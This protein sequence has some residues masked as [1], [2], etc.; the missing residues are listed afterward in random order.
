MHSN[1][2][3]PR[4]PRRAGQPGDRQPRPSRPAGEQ[5]SRPAGSGSRRPESRRRQPPRRSGGRY[6]RRA[7]RRPRWQLPALIGGAALL[8]ALVIFLIAR[9]GG[10]EDRPDKPGIF[11]KPDATQETVVPEK[12]VSTVTLGSMGDLVM[13]SQLLK[14]ARQED[15]SY[16]FDYIFRYLGDYVAGL[17]YAAV[18]LETS[19]GGPDC[20]TP[21]QGNPRF[22]T[23]DAILDSLKKAG[24]DMMLTANNHMGDTQSEGVIR[25][26]EQIRSRDL[27]ALGTNLPGEDTRYSMVELDGI[28]LGLVNYTFAHNVSDDGR[29]SLNAHDFLSQK[30]LVNFFFDQRLDSF[31]G[32]L[33]GILQQMEADGANFKIVYLHWGTEYE[34]GTTAV[35]K[36]IAQKLC[37]LGVDVIIGGHPHVAEP[38]ELLSSQ[39]DPDHKTVCLYS[40]GNFVSN[41][42]RE[43]MRLNT[44]HTEDGLMFN[45]TFEKYS[46]G[47]PYLLDVDVLPT[48]VKMGGDQ[49]NPLD[50]AVLPLDKETQSQWQQLY[51]LTDAQLQECASSY[52]RTMDIVGP[53]LTACKTY[54]A[55]QKTDREQFYWEIANTPE[56]YATGA[57]TAPA[58]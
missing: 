2:E 23:P 3:R 12:A 42:R 54:L 8:L 32:E 6:A 34:L 4:R 11:D 25:T 36:N 51:E 33:G 39:T 10:D 43:M 1:E 46:D 22:N 31:Y 37:D 38:M 26:V 45:L 55:Q 44:G 50:Y 53:G 58:E 49:N 29:P 21:F 19:L 15:Q 30:G 24:Y 28:K 48:W 52:Q 35:Q 13:H 47:R 41:Q 7:P 9:P 56:K 40:M 57:A 20:G 27:T 14:I 5:A 17:D 18:N 16:D